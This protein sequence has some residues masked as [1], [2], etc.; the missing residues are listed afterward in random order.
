MKNLNVMFFITI[1]LLFC[2]SL[3]YYIFYF[4]IQ[5]AKKSL[6]YSCVIIPG[7]QKNNSL[8]ESE[9]GNLGISGMFIHSNGCGNITI[10]VNES[11]PDYI[12]I[13]KHEECHRQ[14]WLERRSFDCN[15]KFGVF[16]NEFE[17][18]YKTGVTK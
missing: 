3:L 10:F 14:Q 13:L 2:L 12:R 6:Y 11:S 8:T 17:C 9:L 18:Y 5:Y 4:E 16:L 1:S 15:F 7:L